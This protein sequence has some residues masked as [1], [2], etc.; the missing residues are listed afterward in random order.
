[1]FYFIKQKKIA[2]TDDEHYQS[3]TNLLPPLQ[4]EGRG[5]VSWKTEKVDYQSYLP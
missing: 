4:G 1:M 5:G 3:S 2:K